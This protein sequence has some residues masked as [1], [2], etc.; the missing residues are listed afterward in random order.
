[1][2]ILNLN[3]VKKKNLS[4]KMDILGKANLKFK[5]KIILYKYEFKSKRNNTMKILV[6]KTNA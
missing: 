4:Q 6:L 1:M 2:I 5:F 3:R